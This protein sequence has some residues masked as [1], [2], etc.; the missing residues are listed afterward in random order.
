M[1]RAKSRGLTSPRSRRRRFGDPERG[2]ALAEVTVSMGVLAIAMS[3]LLQATVSLAHARQISAEKHRAATALS[4]AVETLQSLGP[5]D[6]LATYGPAGAGEAF[7]ASG[8]SAID[9]PGAAPS[10]AIEFFVD[11]TV[12][13]PTLGLPRDLDGDGA[14]ANTDVSTLGANGEAVATILPTRL[15]V[16][17]RSKDGATRTVTWSAM[18]TRT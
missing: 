11:E 18:I 13:E 16:T 6:A 8:L 2:L 15:S 4:R 10:V 3:I 14:I 7:V 12:D 9:A 1:T 17:W 5:D